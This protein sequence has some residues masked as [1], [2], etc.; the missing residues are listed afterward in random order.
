MSSK[1]WEIASRI[2]DNIE[3]AMWSTLF[4]FVIYFITLVLPG[5]PEIQA[6]IARTRAEEIRAE[7]ASLC[8]K[9]GIKTGTDKYN[10]C[11]LDV[12]EFRFNVEKRLSDELQ[13]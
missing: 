6:Q 12:G 2:Y 3:I 5:L 1:L 9:L 7:N 11:L 13:W 4:A 8:E 10:R